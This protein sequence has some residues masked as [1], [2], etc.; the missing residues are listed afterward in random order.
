MHNTEVRKMFKVGAHFGHQTHKW[1]PKMKK[2]IFGSRNGIHIINLEQTVDYLNVAYKFISNI[3]ATGGKI[4][5]IGTKKQA[6]QSILVNA[7]EAKQLYINRRWLGGMLTNFKTIKK[8]VNKFKKIEGMSSKGVFDKLPKKEAINLS[9]SLN[10]FEKNFNG[11]KD[12][13]K[14]PKAIFLIDPKKEYIAINEA[15]KLRIPI[16]AIVDTN[17]NP[18]NIDYII[19]GNDDSIRSINFFTKR[20]TKA[21]L[22][23]ISRRKEIIIKKRLEEENFGKRATIKKNFFESKSSYKKDLK[24]EVI[25]SKLI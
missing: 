11:I 8:S 7:V 19:P 10:K 21:C 3:V 24:I 25:N 18:D 5:F 14:L 23:G 2:Y 17:C 4:L 9:R 22:E 15:K 6:Q 1:N 16:V 12:M 20:I 13:A